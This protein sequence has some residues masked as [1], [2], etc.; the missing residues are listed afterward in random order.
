MLLL[1]CVF[2]YFFNVFIGSFLFG[3]LSVFVFLLMCSYVFVCCLSVGGL[4]GGFIYFYVFGG[5]C[6]LL[7]HGLAPVLVCVKACLWVG[8]LCWCCFV[9]GFVAWCMDCL[10]VRFVLWFLCRLRG[11]CFLCLC[12]YLCVCVFFVGPG[13]GLFKVGPDRLWKFN[14]YF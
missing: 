11:L 1:F 7:A 12:Q 9:C 6:F 14:G 8:L 13:N 5:I 2:A 10:D 3:V 4:W